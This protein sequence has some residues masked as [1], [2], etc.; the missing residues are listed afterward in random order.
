MHLRFRP[1]LALFTLL[2][3]ALLVTLGTWQLDRRAWKQELLA[4]IAA[5][6][7]AA[8][9]GLPARID[10]PS[11][12]AY[13]P[14]RAA[15]RFAPASLQLMGRNHGGRPG[16]KLI[17]LLDRPGQAP[18]TVDLGWRPLGSPAVDAAALGD[19]QLTG[20]AMEMSGE[21]P[22]APAN[23]LMTGQ[24]FWLSP[25]LVTDAL[26]LDTPPL[27]IVMVATQPL[28]GIDTVLI[29]PRTD[30]PDNHL[31]YAL[32]WYSLAAIFVGL[33]VVASRRQDQADE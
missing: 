30:L 9:T 32:T 6:S 27:P 3:V 12:W 2:A 14:I 29:P 8:P 22:F 17:G 18:L 1:G 24:V 11:D 16:Y 31:Q 21:P 5:R 28:P 10:D 23:D 7:D 20:V 33:F 15:G 4:Q 25:A 19:L 26:S 13:L